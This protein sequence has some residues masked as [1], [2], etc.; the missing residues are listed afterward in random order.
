VDGSGTAAAGL[1]VGPEQVS[2]IL[3]RTEP[4][5]PEVPVKVRRVEVA[6]GTVIGWVTRADELGLGLKAMLK[7]PILTVTLVLPPALLL[8]MRSKLRL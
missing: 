4:A 7:D 5:L 2:R 6:A 3:S 8:P 1:H